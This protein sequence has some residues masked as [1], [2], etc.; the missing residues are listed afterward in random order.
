MVRVLQQTSISPS[1]GFVGNWAPDAAECRA[2]GAGIHV[3]PGGAEG[4]G[5][6]CSFGSVRREDSAWRVKAVC[7]ASGATWNANIKLAVS[8]DRLMWS[9]ERGTA[10]Y[11]RC[12]SHRDQ[13]QAGQRSERG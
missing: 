11:V 1:E 2:S 3:G 7:S 8:G 4:Y 6:A 10:V 9:S 12:G 5:G 13:T